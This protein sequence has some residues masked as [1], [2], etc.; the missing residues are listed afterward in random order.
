MNPA[1][2]ALMLTAALVV[3]SY[4]M[5]VKLALLWR[6][7]PENRFDQMGRRLAKLFHLGLAQEKLIG[8][9]HERSSGAMHF[10]IFWGFVVLGLREIIV[11]GEGFQSGFQL[12][13]PIIG[14][15]SFLG[16]AYTFAY[17]LFEAI[18]AAMVVFALYRRVV[19]KPTRLEVS[20][21][22][23]LI[24]GLILG[25]VGTDLLFGAAKENLIVLHGHA[26]P[27]M[28]SSVYG[29][30]MDWS[31][32]AGLIAW[33]I[34]WWNEGALIFLFQF[35]YWGHLA[36]VLVF[37]CILPASKHFHV[38]T[39]L[40]N[41]LFV[42]L[43]RP[44][45]P[46]ALMDLESEEAWEKETIGLNRIE[47]LT[48]KQGLDL[49]T[50]TE[51]G[52]CHD[53]CPTYVTGKPLTLKWFNDD[54]RHHLLEEAG[55][56]LRTGAS[57][58]EKSLVGDVISHDTL[59]ACTTCRA[60]EEVC[61]VGIEHVPRII[62][63]RQGQVLMHENYPEELNSTFK[64]LE[65]NGNPWGI[66]YDKRS[67]WAKGLDIPILGL[68]GETAQSVPDN[69]DVVM[70]VGCMGAYDARNQKIARATATLL[71]K[72]GVRFAILGNAEKCIGDL[73][74]RSGNELLYQ[75]LARENVE[76]LNRHKV[77]HVVTQ[78]PHCLNSLKNEYPQLEGKYEVFHH[79]QYI[80][81][82]VDEGRLVLD[83]ALEGTVTFHDPCYLGRYNGE[84][85]APRTLL[86]KSARQEPVEMHRSRNESFCCGA[87]G[88]RMW[89]EETIGTRVNE[90]RVRQAVEVNAETIVT[91]CPFCM[92][93]ID[94]G[95]KQTGRDETMH[96]R[97]IAEVVLDSLVAPHATDSTDAH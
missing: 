46:I 70:W 26:I 32:M 69:L 31:P 33:L 61:P 15:T 87:G 10:F 48:W 54:L 18:V 91:A 92:T 59:W 40:P 38:I 89:M 74:R 73:A 8:R 50:C 16:Y 41:V 4:E 36:I 55:N 52:R 78:C 83:P 44:H 62:A 63:M 58:G 12:G 90:E 11:F 51:C 22:A 60:C 72:A 20:M 30:E 65:R 35:A 17:D 96:V 7:A 82:L 1:L 97:D 29:T 56:I 84:Y 28:S 85:D 25:V 39:A 79:S 5:Y 76:T 19:I 42:S 88:A 47:Q 57:S 21:E 27:Y 2:T 53:I 66:G 23:Y 64:G 94:D 67:D 49:Y 80:A 68:T 81:R 43:G 77:T 3:F 6:L 34:S 71:Q 86:A 45:T 37:L 9:K 14:A 95:I 75:T 13:L 24:L 93:M